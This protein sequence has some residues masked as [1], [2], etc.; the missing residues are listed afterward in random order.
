MPNRTQTRS[1]TRGLLV[2]VASVAASTLCPLPASAQLPADSIR[3]VDQL[4]A[5]YSHT[6]TP[7]CVVG[8]DRHGQP[9]FRRAYGMANLELGVPLSTSSVLET[10]SVAK[11]FTAAAIVRLA[12]DGK[13]ALDDPVSR[14]LPEL[15]AR[16]PPVTVRMLLTHTAGVRDQWALVALAGL[17]NGQVL[18][19][20][21]QVVAL[22]VRQ[23]GNEFPPN[24]LFAYSNGGYVLLAEI[25]RRVSGRP[26][27]DYARDTFFTP[28]GLT[29]TQWRDDWNRIVP[30]RATAYRPTATGFRTDMPLSN[31]YGQ[32]G[33]LTTVD[34]LLRWNAVLDTHRALRDSLERRGRLTSRRDLEYA[35][36][37]RVFEYRGLREVSHIGNTASYWSYLGRIPAAGLSVAVLCNHGRADAPGLARQVI[38]LL[39]PAGTPA[40][41]TP[42]VPVASPVDS[43]YLGRFDDPR[44]ADLIE[45][46]A[47]D[48]R[49][50]QLRFGQALPL[51]AAGPGHYSWDAAIYGETSRTMTL[52]FAPPVRGQSP[53]FVLAGVD[54]DSVRYVRVSRPATTRAT[55]FAA[56]TGVYH[57]DELGVDYRIRSTGSALTLEVSGIGRL[58]TD[59]GG[60]VLSLTHNSADLFGDPGLITIRFSRVRGRV[61]G[62]RLDFG[63]YLA[64]ISFTRR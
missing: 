13:L 44:S 57:S 54:G 61:T 64:G 49:M 60:P 10:G 11:Q 14:Y 16:T 19:T 27:A 50:V 39:L 33:I 45:I 12:L 17:A 31:V 43:A 51:S 8:A 9:L 5:P 47:R 29:Q 30:G 18:F 37:L 7:G 32:G 28:F 21:E 22:L 3:L 42:V 1:A 34:D 4:F 26:M 58:P 40:A 46:G 24:A 2:L 55:D 36:G 20:M 23:R 35:L 59:L 53:G 38:D 52:A 15:P 48:G 25:V 6:T 56:F 62:F 63:P 41:P